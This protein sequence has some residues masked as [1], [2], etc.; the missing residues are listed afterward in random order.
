MII[1]LC[2]KQRRIIRLASN[3]DKHLDHQMMTNVAINQTLFLCCNP[4]I[5]GSKRNGFDVI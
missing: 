5:A 2:I 4:A 1:E 3:K